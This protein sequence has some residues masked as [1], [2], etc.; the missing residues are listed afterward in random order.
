MEHSISMKLNLSSSS[1]RVSSF[2]ASLHTRHTAVW[3]R[4]GYNGQKTL[5]LKANTILHTLVWKRAVLFHVFWMSGRCFRVH[6]MCNKIKCKKDKWF[7]AMHCLIMQ[8]CFIRP[9]PPNF[10]MSLQK[11]HSPHSFRRHAS[12]FRQRV[13]LRLAPDELRLDGILTAD[14]VGP[15]LGFGRLATRCWKRGVESQGQASTCKWKTGFPGYDW[16]VLLYAYLLT[17][18]QPVIPAI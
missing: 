15:I 17:H 2:P 4:T 10:F 16:R 8:D 6:K 11:W 3:G 13:L 12:H 7:T 18:F 1:P 14:V 9:G 5:R